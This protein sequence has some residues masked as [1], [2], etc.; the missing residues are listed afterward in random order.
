M[1]NFYLNVCIV[2]MH[3]GSALTSFRGSWMNLQLLGTTT[4]Y[5]IPGWLKFLMGYLRFCTTCP[6]Y[7]VLLVSPFSNVNP[8][9]LD[10]RIKLLIKTHPG[11]VSELAE[12]VTNIWI[13]QFF[14]LPGGEEHLCPIDSNLLND[15]QPNVG[16][17]PLMVIEEFQK[18]AHY[19]LTCFSLGQPESVEA[20]KTYFH[21]TFSGATRSAQEPSCCSALWCWECDW[22]LPT[23]V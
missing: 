19:I 7:Q 23:I 1:I 15:L 12:P 22:P 4:E 9:A 10:C 20:T 13:L 18:C 14:C 11:F 5:A 16:S 21:T 8:C 3:F 17:R 2:G 6:N